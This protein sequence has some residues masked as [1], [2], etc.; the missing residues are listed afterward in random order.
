MNDP[1][2]YQGQLQAPVPAQQ[3]GAGLHY[4]EAAGNFLLA[5]LQIFGGG[6]DDDEATEEAPE[7]NRRNRRP[8][9]PIGLGG[10]KPKSGGSCCRAKRPST[11]K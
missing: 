2:T 6:G 11:D 9:F 8:R 4:L 7:Q 1:R 10:A 5:G 3:S